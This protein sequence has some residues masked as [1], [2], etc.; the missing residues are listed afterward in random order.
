MNKLGEPPEELP[1]K[2]QGIPR[3]FWFGMLVRSGDLVLDFGKRLIS[4]RGGVL[5]LTPKAFTLLEIL[6]TNRSEVLSR[7]ELQKR[8]WP[9]TFVVE[10]N[11]T[12]LVSEIRS[13]TGDDPRRPRLIRTVHGLGYAFCG[14]VTR[15]EAANPQDAPAPVCCWLQCGDQKVALAE[16]DHL[17]GRSPRSVL[18][19]DCRDVSRKHARIT[20]GPGS[21]T[22]VDLGSTNGTYVGSERVTSARPLRDGDQVRAG[23][24]AFKV[25]VPRFD[26]T[27]RLTPPAADEPSGVAVA[28]GERLGPAEQ[29]RSGRDEV[30]R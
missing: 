26:P 25:R 2:V 6:V 12:N 8:L 20:V 17:I 16:G 4:Y 5:R 3:F 7:A 23:S 1:G 28:P 22:I 9:D 13:V 21:L 14:K 24:V 30:T 29:G 19:L 18:L 11:L 27:E 15:V 10:A